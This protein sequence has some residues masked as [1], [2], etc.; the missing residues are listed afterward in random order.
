MDG[1]WRGG[2]A[3]L[4]QTA[5]L[6]YSNP[7]RSALDTAD[8]RMEGEARV[9]FPDG[10]MRLENVLDPSLGQQSNFV[11]WCPET[12]PSDIAISWEFRPLREPGLAMMF[13]AASGRQGE[14]LFD[15]ALAERRGEYGQYHSGDINAF[16][17]SYFR[18]RYPEE[19]AF[20]TC[21]LR[22][23]YGAHLVCQGADPIPYAVDAS[24]PYRMLI[25]KSKE[26]LQLFIQE[27]KIFEWRD[28][29]ASWGPLLGGGKIGFRQ[30]A[31][32][33]A[34]YANLQVYDLGKGR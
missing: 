3:V 15:A 28:D 4:P 23:S 2:I 25:V 26:K 11:Y 16:H 31:P 13:L 27:L 18:R 22:K 6:I 19:R 9:S 30:M 5:Q 32:L 21:N 20:H 24:A 1:A 17:V 34:E 10:V 29:G 12:F 7:L 8:F 33:V 14:D